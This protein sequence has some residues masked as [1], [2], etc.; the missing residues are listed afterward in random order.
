LVYTYWNASIIPIK[1]PGLIPALFKFTLDYV[2]RLS[3]F[4]PAG[5]KAVYIEGVRKLKVNIGGINN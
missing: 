5:L 2:K 4:I 3:A 1:L